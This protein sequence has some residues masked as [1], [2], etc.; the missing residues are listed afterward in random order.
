MKQGWE[1]KKLGE[2]CELSAGGD[3]PKDNLSKTKSESY[4][5]PIYANGEKND[6]LYGYTNIAKVVKPSI[7]VS[8][9]GTIGYSVKRLEPFFPV[10][11]LIVVTPKDSSKLGLDYLNY[12]IKTI[13]FK[14]SGTS[15]PQL[16]V[17]MISNYKIPLPPL[18]EQQ[19]IVSILD[20]CF[21]TI[22]KAKANA[23]QNL[24]NARELYESYLQGVFEKKGDGWEE[25]RFEE[26]IRENQIGLIKSTKEQGNDKPYRY[27]KM[28]SITSDNNLVH[29]KYVYVDAS[30]IELEKFALNDGDFLFNT[31]NSYD[32][33]GKTCVF[34]PIDDEPTLF[35][36]NIMR[37]VFNKGIS[38]RFINYAFSSKLVKERLQKLKSGTTS[39]VGI[40]YKGLRNLKIPVTNFKEQQTIVRK[41]DTLRAETQKLEAVYQKKIEDLEELKKSILQRAFI[42]ELTGKEVVV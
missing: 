35:N 30:K 41:L 24:K 37:V 15:I 29:N 38:S 20:E 2:V 12:A 3:V 34:T 11:R 9:R 13:D 18:P 17:P 27:L 32:L 6:G 1:I 25:K 10:V 8:A 39:V 33:V 28:D 42:G 40:Y 7:T 22:D 31:R 21:V 5:I 26:L 23:E 36:N 19:R 16:T 14:H 4:Q